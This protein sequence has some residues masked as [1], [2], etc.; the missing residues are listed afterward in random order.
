MYDAYSV[1]DAILDD[2]A[3]S[4][5]A[6]SSE[7]ATASSISAVVD[8]ALVTPRDEDIAPSAVVEGS[9]TGGSSNGRKAVDWQAWLR[10]DEYERAR[11]KQVGKEREKVLS[12]K[13][14]LNVM[15]C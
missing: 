1:A 8:S 3:S 7:A 12:V 10:L 15:G 13:E 2:Y 14:M 4:Q 5:N 11:G 6:R 9:N